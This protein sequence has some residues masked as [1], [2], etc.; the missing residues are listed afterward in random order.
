MN[1]IKN[2][3]APREQII[4]LFAA[5]VFI[6]H[7]WSIVNVLREVPAWVL[8]LNYWD[9][10][11]VIAYTQVYALIES[12]IVIVVL[13]VIAALLP[14][15]LFRNKFVA[16][17]TMIVVVTSIWFILAHYND[18]VIRLWGA[19]QFIIFLLIFIVSLL[20]PYL[21]IQRYPKLENTISSIVQRIAVL[22]YVYVTLDIISIFIIIIRN[23]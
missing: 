21:L 15:K 23:R 10:F 20:A 22:A 5:C 8:R 19:K 7:V 14:A 3:F 12:V 4:L 2:R 1:F 17:G 18:E 16:V 6:I 13:I 11:G 9:L